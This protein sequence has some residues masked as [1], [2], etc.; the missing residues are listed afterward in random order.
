MKIKVLIITLLLFL[1]SCEDSSS[2]NYL[3]K[4]ELGYF[5]FEVDGKF[6][7][8]KTDMDIFMPYY[9][10]FASMLP[11]DKNDTESYFKMAVEAT[12]INMNS[13]L[14]FPVDSIEGE[15]RYNI[16]DTIFN[17]DFSGYYDIFEF[18][19]ND[20]VYSKVI[21][22]KSWINLEYLSKVENIN[23][24]DTVKAT[25]QIECYN[26]ADTITLRNGF[27]YMYLGRHYSFY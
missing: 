19:I 25:F 17:S 26:D 6:W 22:S 1:V 15:G 9:S 13:Y 24:F 18:V 4:D 12:N 7:Y 10:H 16:K 11:I 14:R 8:P 20:I 5:S 3:D 23:D 21:E 27:F 2:P